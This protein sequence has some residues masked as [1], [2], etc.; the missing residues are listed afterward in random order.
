MFIKNLLRID[1]FKMILR[2][3]LSGDFF[4]K[5]DNIFITVAE[6]VRHRWIFYKKI[7]FIHYSYFSSYE[8]KKYLMNLIKF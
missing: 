3:F 8:S 6:K 5:V 1:D 7:E 4:R 2:K